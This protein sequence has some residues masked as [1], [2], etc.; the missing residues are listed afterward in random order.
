MR[1]PRTWGDGTKTLSRSSGATP[2]FA[3]HEAHCNGQKIRTRLQRYARL[4]E[5][6]MPRVAPRGQASAHLVHT[7]SIQIP[8]VLGKTNIQA[9]D[10]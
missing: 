3:G 1:E 9:V 10:Q 4:S 8:D 7:F 6:G 5:R 2:G